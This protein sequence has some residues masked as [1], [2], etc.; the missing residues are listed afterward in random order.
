MKRHLSYRF[1]IA[2]FILFFVLCKIGFYLAE[3]KPLWNDEFYS[4]IATI[5]WQTYG[6]ILLGNATEG[7]NSPLFFIIQKL[8]CDFGDY[9]ISTNWH[10]NQQAW[11]S[12]DFSE[13]FLR[14]NPVVFMSLS[15]AVI[16]YFFHRFYSFPA[17]MLSLIVSLSSYMVWAYWAEARPYALWVFLTTTQSLLFL[18]L[19]RNVKVS[20]ETWNWLVVNHILLSM[21]SVFSLSQIVIVS[22]LLWIFLERRWQKYILLTLIPSLIC[23]FYYITSASTK[24][25]FWFWHSPMQLINASISKDRFLI[26]FI[27][28]VCFFM[29][30]YQKKKGYPQIFQ[31]RFM[32]EGLPYLLS[33]IL[34][35]LAACVV[36]LLFK[37]GDDGSRQGFFISN[38]YFI[39]LTPIGIIA[40]THFVMQLFRAL[41]ERK[42]L[43]SLMFLGI[44]F[45]VILRLYR[46]LGIVKGL[47]P[48]LLKHTAFLPWF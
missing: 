10:H 25:Q 36:L 6:G 38:R 47:Y 1:I 46:T 44:M 42:L 43:K 5:D 45:M 14:I 18:S 37:L 16:F 2:F 32:K 22:F 8:F 19:M 15:I 41:N 12:D 20:Q 26:I 33:T 13:I 11:I 27:F 23:I 34:M 9:A 30:Y 29:S 24:F 3:R 39:Y 17:A 48:F 7:N 31:Y 35:V 21:T 28:I 4:Q 40:V